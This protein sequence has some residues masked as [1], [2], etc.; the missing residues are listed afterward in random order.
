MSKVV[1][2]IRLGFKAVRTV[3]LGLIWILRTSMRAVYIRAKNDAEE[4]RKSFSE[5][6]NTRKRER[7]P[8][9][10]WVSAFIIIGVILAA[11][12]VLHMGL[13][14]IGIVFQEA[15][16]DTVPSVSQEALTGLI[17]VSA[18]L[19]A[20]MLWFTRVSNKSNRGRIKDVGRIFLFAALSLSL[21]MLL[22]P[23][24]PY[25]RSNTDLYGNFLKAVT[26]ISFMGGSISFAWAT[27]LGLAYLWRL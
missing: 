23:I 18:G 8:V 20:L 16:P 2:I 9:N 21:F 24:L 11:F 7:E 17:L 3:G 19:G 22:S 15:D 27:L 6:R 1:R 26:V 5:W 12:L 25:I 14:A 4:L 10:V 13:G